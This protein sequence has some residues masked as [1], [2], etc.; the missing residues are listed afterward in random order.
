MR[1][2]RHDERL[3][4]RSV[5]PAGTECA[6]PCAA[7]RQDAAGWRCLTLARTV[8]PRSYFVW[9][10]RHLTCL[11]SLPCSSRLTLCLVSLARLF[12]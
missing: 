3:V 7:V 9:Q 2:D 4:L 10:A 11:F 12:A 5:R 6:R 1:P 8:A